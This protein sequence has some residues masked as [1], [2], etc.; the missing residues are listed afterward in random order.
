MKAGEKGASTRAAMSAAAPILFRL[1]KIVNLRQVGAIYSD[2]MFIKNCRQPQ[3][4]W[5]AELKGVEL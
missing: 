5:S 2:E 1:I 3:G 4:P